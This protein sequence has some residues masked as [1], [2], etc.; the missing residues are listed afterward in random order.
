MSSSLSAWPSALEDP[1]LDLARGS[2]R[3]DDAT[4]VVHRPD[5]LDDDLAE[6]GIDRN[7]G[8]LAAERLN[9]HAVGVRPRAPVVFD[10]GLAE[11][12]GHLGDGNVDG[13]VA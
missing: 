7:L 13:S 10:R 1:A 11:L 12:P 9:R 8:D 2:E 6:P 3:V 4:D 5:P